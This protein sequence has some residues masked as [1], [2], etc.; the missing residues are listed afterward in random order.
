MHMHMCTACEHAHAYA[1][2]HAHRLRACT[3]PWVWACTGACVPM[4]ASCEH[5]RGPELTAWSRNR[6]RPSRSSWSLFG[7]CVCMYVCMY[8]CM[9]VSVCLCV[10]QYVSVA[11]RG[12]AVGGSTGG[13]QGS[14][15]VEAAAAAAAA[16]AVAAAAAAAAGVVR[17]KRCWRDICRPPISLRLVLRLPLTADSSRTLAAASPHWTPARHFEGSEAKQGTT[18]PCERWPP[19]GNKPKP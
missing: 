9:C 8:V 11:V 1:Y 7:S 17:G 10:W 4:H 19:C 14:G 15:G 3:W 16:A 5:E 18:P 12:A 2:A 13:C 6:Q